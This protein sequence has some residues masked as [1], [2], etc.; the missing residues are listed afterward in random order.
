V[1]T[2]K[3]TDHGRYRGAQLLA[4]SESI[5]AHRE[6]GINID[7]QPVGSGAIETVA[8]D[9]TKAGRKVPHWDWGQIAREYKK[10]GHWAFSIRS[11]NRLVAVVAARA[12]KD[13]VF[14][15]FMEGDPGDDAPLKG[16]RFAVALDLLIRYAEACELNEIRICPLTPELV[17]WYKG[18]AEFDPCPSDEKPASFA[19][20]I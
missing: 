12:A 3:K 4:A 19:L 18:V 20:R 6:E 8:L 1:S 2:K 5:K 10:S 11:D 7:V 17:M 16:E 15:D 14:G 13:H 9:W